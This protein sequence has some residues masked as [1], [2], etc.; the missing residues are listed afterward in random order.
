MCI[1]GKLH[2]FAYFQPAIRWSRS[3]I[4]SIFIAEME[5]TGVIC[6]GTTLFFKDFPYIFGY[7]EARKNL[8]MPK[9]GVGHL[10][11]WLLRLE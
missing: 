4:T 10:G 9:L 8:R 6:I 7:F 2:Y 5:S 1:I 11:L 3:Q